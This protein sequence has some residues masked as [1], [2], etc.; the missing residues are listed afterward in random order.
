MRLHHRK[1]KVFRHLPIFRI[2]TDFANSPGQSCA[3]DAATSPFGAFAASIGGLR[4]STMGHDHKMETPMPAFMFVA[5]DA[6]KTGSHFF[7]RRSGSGFALA[8]A[9][10]IAASVAL[11]ALPAHAAAYMKLG[12]IKGQATASDGD[13]KNFYKGWIELNSVTCNAARST[14]SLSEIVVTKQAD[15]SSP[16]LSQASTSR[17]K[18]PSGQI[19]VMDASGGSA[20]LKYELK[21]VVITS[22]QTGAAPAAD[23]SIPIETLSL[24]F[25][26]VTWV[27][28]DGSKGTGCPR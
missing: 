18:F 22:Y 14:P 15:S 25:D 20:Q 12:D 21:N 1:Y 17:R 19:H 28:G 10:A 5:P 23:G 4:P 7:A 9:F 26:K 24:D 16:A 3:E 11:G 13:K 8:S 6:R 2:R 27:A